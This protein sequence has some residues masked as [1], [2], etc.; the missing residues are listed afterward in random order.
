M[1][2]ILKEGDI[3]FRN[4]NSKNSDYLDQPATKMTYLPKNAKCR[5]RHTKDE[6]YKTSSLADKLEKKIDT[7]F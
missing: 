6:R 7:C 5:G 1:I 3:V 2:P 4:V